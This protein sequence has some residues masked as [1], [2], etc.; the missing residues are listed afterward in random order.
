MSKITT[1]FYFPLLFFNQNLK[2]IFDPPLFFIILHNHLVTQ[3]CRFCFL[4]T[5]QYYFPSPL[6]LLISD[7]HCFLPIQGNCLLTYC[8]ASSLILLPNIPSTAAEVIFLKPKPVHVTYW[9]HSI[10]PH[11]MQNKTKTFWQA[12]K[13]TNDLNPF[14]YYTTQSNIS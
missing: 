9:S 7:T 10:S 13:A 1:V 3:H 6:L 2:S 4:N 8:P 12:Y 11:R 5:S 14:L